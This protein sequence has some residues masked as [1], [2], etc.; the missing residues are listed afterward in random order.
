MGK[1]T[2][3]GCLVRSREGEGLVRAVFEQSDEV[4]GQGM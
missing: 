4:V 2:F 1:T 3:A